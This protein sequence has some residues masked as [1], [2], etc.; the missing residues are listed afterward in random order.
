MNYSFGI[1]D[2]YVYSLTMSSVF[3]LPIILRIEIKI[4]QYDDA[5]EKNRAEY[6]SRCEI[7]QRISYLETYFADVKLMPNPPAFV[8]SKNTSMVSSSLN[9]SIKTCLSAILVSPSKRKYL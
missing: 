7:L 2:I 1:G 5:V 9:W 8:L 6:I 3:S 4:I